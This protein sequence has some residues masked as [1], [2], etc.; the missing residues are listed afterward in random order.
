MSEKWNE[1]YAVSLDEFPMEKIIPSEGAYLVFKSK[2]QESR[3][4][5]FDLIIQWAYLR[6]LW[7]QLWWCSEAFVEPYTELRVYITKISQ[8]PF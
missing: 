2:L 3:E 7:G 6:T 5:L 4:F 8:E 1:K